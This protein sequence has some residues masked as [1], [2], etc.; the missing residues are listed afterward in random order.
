MNNNS[1]KIEFIAEH[2]PA[3][4]HGD[5]KITAVQTIK[6]NSSKIPNNTD[7]TAKTLF[8][9]AGERF[10]LN[11][12]EVLT[13]FPP[14]HSLG[15]H[16]SVL[17]HI[18]LKRSTLP[19][20]RAAQSNTPWLALLLFNSDEAA[21][22]SSSNVTLGQ[23]VAQ[24]TAA[25]TSTPY[26]PGLMLENGQQDT[27]AVTV[28]DVP[29]STLERIMPSAD[30]LKLLSHVRA[31]ADSS[32]IASG[33]EQAVILSNRLP[34]K[35][36]TSTMHLVSVEG[37][38]SGGNFNYQGASVADEVR[39]VSLKNW[40]FSCPE[41]YKISAE[42]LAHASD[43]SPAIKGKLA[44]LHDEEFF[45]TAAFDTRLQQVLSDDEFFGNQQSIHTDFSYGDLANTLKHLNRTP[46]TLSLGAPAEMNAENADHLARGFVPIPHQLRQG[47]SGVSWYHGPLAAGIGTDNASVDFPILAADQLLRYYPGSSMLDISY[48]AAWELG[49]LLALQDKDFARQLFAWKRGHI[50]EV[51]KAEQLLAHEAEHLNNHSDIDVLHMPPTVQSWF[52]DLHLLK[53]VPFTYLVPHQEMLPVEAIRFFAIDPLWIHSIVDGAFSIGRIIE[54]DRQRDADHLCEQLADHQTTTG[55]LLRSH[56]VSGWPGLQIEGFSD[57]AATDKLALVRMERLSADVLL[58]L[59][60]GTVHKVDMHLQPEAMHFGV[61]TKT[62]GYEK[63]LKHADGQNNGDLKQ[64]VP[65]RHNSTDDRVI[66]VA[67]LADINILNTSTADKFALQM[68]EGVSKVSFSAS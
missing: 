67:A 40:Q 48:A 50:H 53:G 30:E 64:D 66:D 4:E 47:G 27:T 10:H 54:H 58:C 8:S 32:G 60:A 25:A 33:E 43:L 44:A 61:S 68:V 36:E 45:T 38:F 31:G 24:A 35:G 52:T 19:W 56:A 51:R 6:D 12:Q 26:I 2:P 62:G 29:R 7:F 28:I 21:E 3:L 15:E 37:R 65:F 55:F 63:Q 18:S 11:P 34:G 59:F 20:E 23:L 9:V 16:S 14:H 13:L 46:A 5:Y 22:I 49:R 41:H 42:F 57:A 1:Q 17:P 39:L